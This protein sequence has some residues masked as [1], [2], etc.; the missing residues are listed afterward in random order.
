MLDQLGNALV[1]VFGETIP[2]ER[3]EESH[4]RFLELTRMAQNNVYIVAGELRSSFFNN[5]F[6]T[7]IKKKIEANEKFKIFLL[8]FKCQGEREDAIK[9]IQKENKGIV[10][11]FTDKKNL[12]GL[13]ENKN[14]KL[15]LADRRPIYH[16]HVTD[17]WVYLEEPHDPDMPRDV[18]IQENKKLADKYIKVFFKLTEAT[19]IDSKTNIVS[20]L[21]PLEFNLDAAKQTID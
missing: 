1:R 6:A 18:Y 3:E 17:N 20:E 12:N 9:K 8:F 7:I 21:K 19:D 4:K 16:F 14:M 11:I 10:K 15:F 2:K 5:D 13:N